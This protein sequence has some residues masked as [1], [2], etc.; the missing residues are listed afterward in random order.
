L[1]SYL[2]APEPRPIKEFAMSFGDV[3]ARL[4]KKS[5]EQPLPMRRHRAIIKNCTRCGRVFWGF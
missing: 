3:A 5:D 2:S 4:R 1:K